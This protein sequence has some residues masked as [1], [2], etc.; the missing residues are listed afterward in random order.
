[1]YHKW[2]NWRY[3]FIVSNQAF[4]SQSGFIYSKERIRWAEFHSRNYHNAHKFKLFSRK[5]TSKISG[6]QSFA[7]CWRFP[8]LLGDWW[9]TVRNRQK[10]DWHP[11]QQSEQFSSS[12]K[13]QLHQTTE[14]KHIFVAISTWNQHKERTTSTSLQKQWCQQWR[15]LPEVISRRTDS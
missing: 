12:F 8:N 10:T 6:S 7:N 4:W 1:M 15:H 9:E 13:L 3:S 2:F 5:I 14:W 11:Q